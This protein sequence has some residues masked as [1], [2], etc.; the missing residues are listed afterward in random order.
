MAYYGDDLDGDCQYL[1][2]FDDASRLDPYSH[3]KQAG[4][5]AALYVWEAYDET[6]SQ[7][8]VISTYLGDATSNQAEYSA[9]ILGLEAAYD[10]G[11]RNIQVTGDSNLVVK[12]VQGRWQRR[13]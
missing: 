9:L 4:A 11:V 10:A 7:I 5:G 12:Q 1:L 13:S 3:E 8:A 2:E 6:W